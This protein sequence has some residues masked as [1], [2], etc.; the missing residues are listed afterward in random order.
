MKQPV[1]GIIGNKRKPL[2][3][4]VAKQAIKFLEQKE[5]PFFVDSGFLKTP[6][7]KKL[8]NI[9][10]D[11]FLVFGGDG[12]ML[13]A[14]R[15]MRLQ[16]PV[17]GI[18]CGKHGHLMRAKAKDAIF[19]IKKVLNDNFSIEKRSRLTIFIDNNL[20]PSALNEI[21][22]APKKS[23][24]LFDFMILV[25]KKQFFSSADA[26]AIATPTGSTGFVASAGGKKL[27]VSRKLLE[28]FPVHAFS[29]LKKP[30]ILR[31]NCKLSVFL[32]EKEAC[33]AIIDGQVRIP[34]RKNVVVK[35]SNAPA[36]FVRLH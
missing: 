35:K 22:V 11:F 27:P 3:I 10:A 20:A 1:F 28:L 36:L 29:G 25:G 30:K 8:K 13:Y 31:D 2:A 14:V 21:I 12:T 33:D 32:L 19:A 7:S 24:T 23:F 9:S 5:L 34:I 16:K 17:L 4:K 26:I 15:E 6:N 18:N